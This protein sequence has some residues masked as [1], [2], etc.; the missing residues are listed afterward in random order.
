MGGLQGY[1]LLRW[2]VCPRGQAVVDP[3]GWGCIESHVGLREWDPTENVDSSQM[4]VAMIVNSSELR[5]AGFTLWE[6]FSSELETAARRRSTR[7][8]GIRQY[9][10]MD[11][12]HVMLSLDDDTEFESRFEWMCICVL[13]VV[14]LETKKNVQKCH[15]INKIKNR[16][17]APYPQMSGCSGARSPWSCT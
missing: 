12:K 6:V 15:E 14:S 16:A 4:P 1:T 2:R 5:A 11:P 17:R 13:G 7:G 3:C 8:A 10:G 9:E